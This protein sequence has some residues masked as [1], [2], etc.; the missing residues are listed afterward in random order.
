VKRNIFAKG[1]GLPK[2]IDLFQQIR[3]CAQ[4]A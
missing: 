3:P 4:A 1:T 2:S